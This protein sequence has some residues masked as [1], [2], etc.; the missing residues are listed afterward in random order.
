MSTDLVPATLDE[1]LRLAQ[2]LADARSIPAA[3]RRSPSDVLLALEY[4]RALGIA[5]TTALTSVYVVDGRPSMSAELM[6]GLVLRDGHRFRVVESTADRCVV[7]VA[8][9]E[10]PD[11][12]S[13]FTYTT[14]D[15][16]RAGLLPAK[17]GS[18][19]EKHP[20]AMLLARVTSFACRATFADTLAGVSYLPDEVPGGA[21]VPVDV[22]VGE[23]VVDPRPANVDADGVID[24]DEVVVDAE[25]VDPDDPVEEP[26]TRSRPRSSMDRTRDALDLPR[27]GDER[28]ATTRQLTALGARLGTLGVREPV[29]RRQ[30]V[31]EALGLTRPL[32]SAKELTVEEV[33]RFLDCPDDV[34]RVAAAEAWEKLVA[35]DVLADDP[36]DA[37]DAGEPVDDPDVVEEPA[38]PVD[39][40]P[41]RP[42]LIS[43]E[44]GR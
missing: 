10:Y 21:D 3:Y 6:R 17:K 18:S 9:R 32:A 11:D 13:T 5:P 15:A 1:R 29:H 35:G 44:D 7:E 30:T 33:S 27:R 36:A 42:R 4:G 26:S 23:L 28:P 2:C 19:W 34:I 40:P 22:V 16:E 31:V 24:S 41:A 38:A 20:A 12:R 43:T 8:R 14:A 39:G 25:V 37:V